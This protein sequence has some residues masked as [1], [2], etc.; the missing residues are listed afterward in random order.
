MMR[1]FVGLAGQDCPLLGENA[2]ATVPAMS[3]P[4]LPARI[5][6]PRTRGGI[7]RGWII[8]AALV[9]A[10][11]EAIATLLPNQLDAGVLALV[12]VTARTSVVWFVLAFAAAPLVALWPTPASKYL[13]RNRRYLG[14]AMAVS[15]GLH[16][17]GILL[18]AARFGSAFW[19][20]IAPTTL[21]GGGLGYVLLAA[22]VA[23]S[24]DRAVVWLGRRRWRTLHLTGMW[25][26]WSIFTFTYVGQLG[27]TVTA[28]VIVAVMFGLAAL[29][30]AALAHRITRRS[31]ARHTT[32]SR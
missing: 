32:G 5:V 11:V 10:L 30:G 18:L 14:L 21:I 19:S 26:F 8:I 3:S 22:M 9:V 7:E 31:V 23:T 17:I 13:L 12:R 15:H 20:A 1:G 25:F 28:D 2:V 29:R 6:D 24:S 16:L 27:R 4:R